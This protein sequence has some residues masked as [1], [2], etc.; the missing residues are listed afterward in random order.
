MHSRR[1][2]LVKLGIIGIGT[3]WE[4]ELRPALET[5]RERVSI[6]AIQ[7][8]VFQRAATT[9]AAYNS[10]AVA[11]ISTLLKRP[12]IDGFLLLDAGWYS[13]EVFRWLTNL[14]R[15]VFLSQACLSSLANSSHCK[16]LYDNVRRDGTCLF[17]ELGHRY[18]PAAWRTQELTAT[19]LG[20]VEDINIELQSI[21]H[22]E[23]TLTDELIHWVDWCC[24]LLRRQP[25]TA[26]LVTEPK[27]MKLQ[28]R[29]HINA[30]TIREA[31]IC[32]TSE[33][34]LQEN[35]EELLSSKRS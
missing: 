32:V 30:E 16:A 7:D 12:D 28:L 17:P 34:S 3:S 14:N 1:P 21:A 13:D 9:A 8:C 31:T 27:S 19:K 35:S 11:G 5:F 6:A 33:S 2:R 10:T 26:K 22:D 29:F 4:T 23:T 15:P 20:S 18:S 24:L 25:T